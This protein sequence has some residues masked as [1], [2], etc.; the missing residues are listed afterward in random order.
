LPSKRDASPRR[1]KREEMEKEG[2]KNEDQGPV[3]Q[4]KVELS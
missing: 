2:E 3:I 1:E 4:E